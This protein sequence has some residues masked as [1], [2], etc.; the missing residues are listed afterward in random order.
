MTTTDYLINAAFVL[1]VLSLARERR[2]DLR[3][4]LVPL[5]ILVLVRSAIDSFSASRRIDAAAWPVA[6]LPSGVVHG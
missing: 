2:L 1:I 6:I 3:S 4:F 5:V